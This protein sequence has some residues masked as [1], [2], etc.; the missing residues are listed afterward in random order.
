MP[1]DLSEGALLFSSADC[2][3]GPGSGSGSEL[4]TPQT[5]GVGVRGGAG[6]GKV[7]PPMMDGLGDK[8]EAE[9]EAARTRLFFGDRGGSARSLGPASQS[10]GQSETTHQPPIL[11]G[12]GEHAHPGSRELEHPDVDAQQGNVR[13]ADARRLL[14]AE[15]AGAGNS[16]L[17]ASSRAL[18]A[19]GEAD[20]LSPGELIEA[21]ADAACFEF[22]D[23]AG[24]GLRPLPSVPEEHTVAG[25]AN[26]LFQFVKQCSQ[27]GTLDREAKQKGVSA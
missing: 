18:E 24:L 3:L 7:R 27:S 14:A 19:R 11:E 4:P 15:T 12:C 23:A 5:S 22:L 9:P 21:P 2:L 10:A 6:G 25:W 26:F 17:G 20:C 8:L 1:D 13:P 16:A